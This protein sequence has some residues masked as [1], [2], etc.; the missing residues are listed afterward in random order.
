MKLDR[1]LTY[2]HHLEALRKKFSTRVSLLRRL[3]GSGRGA[4]AKTLR[5]T[6]LSL[7]Y[8]TAKYCTPAWC[9][10]AHTRLIYSVLNDTLLI[11]TGCLRPTPTDN[12]PVLSGI[13]P[14][15]LSR[16]GATLYLADHSSLDEQWTNWTWDTEYSKSMSALRVCIPRVRTRPIEMSLTRT[17]WVKLNRL[18][19][20]I[21]RFG[22][23]IHKWGL[24]SSAKCECGASE[25]TA[26]HIVLTCPIYRVSRGTTSLTVLDDETRGWLNSVTASI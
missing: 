7:I 4:G 18:H 17:A 20:G 9:R 22:L 25:Q 19:T 2:R 21:G 13:Q 3:A 6:A 14:A 1:E 5:R 10:S 23:S 16:Q 11:V 15:E 26:D 8:S 12:L 24:A